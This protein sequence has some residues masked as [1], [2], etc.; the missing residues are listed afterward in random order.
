MGFSPPAHASQ[1]SLEIRQLPLTPSRTVR[2]SCFCGP[3]HTRCPSRH[4]YVS[5][6]KYF[7]VLLPDNTRRRMGFDEQLVVRDVLRR[8]TSSYSAAFHGVDVSS[9]G[10]FVYTSVTAGLSRL[11]SVPG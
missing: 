5:V 9:W 3:L 11:L 1:E 7:T 6:Q 2:F 8:I 4:S 10:L